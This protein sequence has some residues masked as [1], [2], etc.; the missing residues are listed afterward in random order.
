MR[1][2][3]RYVR[4]VKE[5]RGR[6]AYVRFETVP[7]L[8]AQVDFSDFKVVEADGRQTTLYSF[9]MVL[10]FSRHMYVE[11]VEHCTMTSFL[12]CHQRA[13]GI[14]GASFQRFSTTT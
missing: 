4:E 5:D 3:K 13:F 11:F 7:G 1:T 10:G 14:L 2:V 6:V 8:Q 12:D 9:M